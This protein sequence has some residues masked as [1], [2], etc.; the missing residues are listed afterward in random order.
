MQKGEC[1]HLQFHTT[2]DWMEGHLNPADGS[3][4]LVSPAQAQP[5]ISKT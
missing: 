3:S 1:G 5:T 4:E 2:K